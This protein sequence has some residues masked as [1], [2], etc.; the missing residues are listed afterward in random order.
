M[1]L[2]IG[3][4]AKR[5]PTGVSVKELQTQLETDRFVTVYTMLKTLEL[6]GM[7]VREVKKEHRKDGRPPGNFRLTEKGKRYATTYNLAP[8]A[9][10][11]PFVEVEKFK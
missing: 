11:P 10:N 8:L 2:L 4:L 7:V 6:T 9:D 5:D 3:V 1:M